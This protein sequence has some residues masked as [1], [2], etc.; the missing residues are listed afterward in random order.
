[1]LKIRAGSLRHRIAIQE[2]VETPDGMGGSS[3]SWSAVSGMDSVP[4]SIMPLT[5]KEQIDALKLESVITN[6]IR[7]WYRAGITSKNRIVFGSRIFNIKG[8]PI[9]YDEKNRT[10]D[11]LV[12]EDI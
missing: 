3:L 7:I 1:M 2:A 5:S 9:N 10:L 11:F 6:K 8:A 12:T 4:A